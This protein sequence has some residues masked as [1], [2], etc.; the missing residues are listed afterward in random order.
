MIPPNSIPKQIEDIWIFGSHARGDFNTGSDID[1][2]LVS[3]SVIDQVAREYF[4]ETFGPSADLATY[5]YKGLTQVVDRG[6]LFAWHLKNEAT[7]LYTQGSRVKD[8][9][10]AVPPYTAHSSDLSVLI[11]LTI[12]SLH[13]LKN[14]PN[15][16]IFD[17]GVLGTSIRN[18]GI[19]MC[20]FL[21]KDNFSPL[22]PLKLGLLDNTLSLPISD[23]D[24]KYLQSCRK[25][26]ERGQLVKEWKS[27][28][29]NVTR[30]FPKIFQWQKSCLDRVVGANEPHNCSAHS[31]P[32]SH[33]IHTERKVLSTINYYSSYFGSQLAGTSQ[34]AIECWFQRI[35]EKRRLRNDTQK[36]RS[37]LDYLGR[38]TRLASSGSHRGA[39]IAPVTHYNSVDSILGEIMSTLTGTKKIQE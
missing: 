3:D 23:L 14:S 17:L 11:H 32:F 35:P 22:S 16:W 4:T 15:T 33:R 29:L 34:R 26:S 1:L 20:N 10:N 25:F 27:Q 37:Q 31:H 36:I 13:S 8:L 7:P 24:Y 21:G 18:T 38:I 6:S 30:L 12:E 9:L 28:I 39:M 2:L 19:V 5:T